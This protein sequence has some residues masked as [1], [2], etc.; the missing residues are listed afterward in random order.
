M[1]LP[2]SFAAAG[3]LP[4]DIARRRGKK[5]RG[6]M[7]GTQGGANTGKTE[8]ILSAPGPGVCIC[9]DRGFDAIFD[10][11]EPPPTRRNDYGFV[12]CK[13]PKEG[14]HSDSKTGIEKFGEYWKVF[15]NAYIAAL[16]NPDT[17]TVAVDGDSDTWEM[18]RL[19][20]W[21][22]LT[23]FPQVGF[24]GVNAARKV[25]YNRAWDSGKIII[26]TNK[27]KEEWK[28]VLDGEGHPIIDTETGKNKQA[29]T[30]KWERQGYPDYQY[31]FQ[32][33]LEHLYRSK[34]TDRR[35]KEHAGEWG[36]KILECK[37]NSQYRGMEL[38]GADCCF[39][40]LME[41]VYP[42]VDLAEW[43]F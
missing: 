9:V 39:Q 15:Y 11:P 24:K 17:R 23:T 6:L 33:Q 42:H 30:G 35:G 28:D 20:E 5:Y 34:Y 37:A 19:A 31:L 13:A 29:K 4:P 25:M 27:V 21:G 1:S 43:G 36:I 7:V 2:A 3:F 8:F 40:T 38:W 18:Q 10:N 41:L 14:Q 22:H 26:C 32:I 12:V 16:D